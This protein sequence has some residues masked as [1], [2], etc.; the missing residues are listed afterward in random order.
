MQDVR[1]TR[2]A[3]VSNNNPCKQNKRNTK[4]NSKDF[5]F[6][7]VNTQNDDKCIQKRYEPP[8]GIPEQ[9]L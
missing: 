1:I 9:I 8:A 3:E 4:G 6:T 5:H 2:K 7:Q